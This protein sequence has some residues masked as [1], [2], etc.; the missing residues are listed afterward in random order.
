LKF[1]LQNIDSVKLSQFIKQIE[2]GLIQGELKNLSDIKDYIAFS[3][4]RTKHKQ[5]FNKLGECFSISNIIIRDKLS[6]N[7][8]EVALYFAHN[9]FCGYVF[10]SPVQDRRHITDYLVDISL[11]NEGKIGENEFESIKQ[12]FS[13]EELERI[14]KNDIYSSNIN[15]VLYY[16]IKE[17]DDGNFIGINIDNNIYKISHDPFEVILLER[18]NL[19]NILK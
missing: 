9:I 19:I 13:N 11:I 5:Y 2:D 14:N 6:S 16:H 8:F 4:D 18:N 17:L 12:L 7:R 3:F 15:G 1:I 10:S